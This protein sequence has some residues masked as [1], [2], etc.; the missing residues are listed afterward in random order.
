M[1]I[2]ILISHIISRESSFQCTIA[3]GKHGSECVT[4]A[5]KI[6][7]RWT[8]EVS[9]SQSSVQG[10]FMTY[11]SRARVSHVNAAQT[12]LFMEGEFKGNI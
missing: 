6:Q 5:G 9:V 7:W 10:H 1:D 8:G 11:E 2:C 12:G 3:K 4:L